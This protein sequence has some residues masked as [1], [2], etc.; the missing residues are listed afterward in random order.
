MVGI[1]PPR[2]DGEIEIDLAVQSLVKLFTQNENVEYWWKLRSIQSKELGCYPFCCEPKKIDLDALQ[3]EPLIKLA[4]RTKRLNPKIAGES[5][6]YLEQLEN[7]GLI[8]KAIQKRTFIRSKRLAS[9]MTQVRLTVKAKKLQKNEQKYLYQKNQ[10]SGSSFLQIASPELTFIPRNV[11]Y[12]AGTH[13]ELELVGAS[14]FMPWIWVRIK[15]LNPK[16]SNIS[17]FEP[18][19]SGDLK[20]ILSIS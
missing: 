5:L 13:I 18:N 14:I 2:D 4:M 8:D 16:S 7:F 11:K 20:Y 1:A 12:E 17:V 3:D 6:D 9:F 15:E 10:K 19:F